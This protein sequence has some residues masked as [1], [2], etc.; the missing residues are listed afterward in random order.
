MPPG[1][2]VSSIYRQAQDI[3]YE[4]LHEGCAFMVLQAPLLDYFGLHVPALD[5]DCEN[6]DQVIEASARPWTLHPTPC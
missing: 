5:P 3:A 6:L 1:L 2:R 4:A